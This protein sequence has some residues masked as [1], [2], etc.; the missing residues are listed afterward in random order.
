MARRKL[1]CRAVEMFSRAREITLCV[2]CE[3]VCVCVCVC[4]WRCA[5]PPVLHEVHRDPGVWEELSVDDH[6]QCLHEVHQRV[7]SNA[8][9]KGLINNRSTIKGQSSP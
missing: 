4:V 5:R 8:V 1:S 6:L 7:L 3:G 2:R 9:R